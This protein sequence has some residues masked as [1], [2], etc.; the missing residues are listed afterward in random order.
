MNF[1]LVPGFL[2]GGL[3]TIIVMI[4]AVCLFRRVVVYCFDGSADFYFKGGLFIL[5]FNYVLVAARFSYSEFTNV[6]F[7]FALFVVV[8][9]VGAFLFVRLRVRLW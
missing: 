7:S 4:S 3:L 8:P 1:G 9:L 6:F 5:A 2:W